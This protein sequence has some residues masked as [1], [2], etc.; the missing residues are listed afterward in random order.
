MA[1]LT[2]IAFHTLALAVAVASAT[3]LQAWNS[4]EISANDKT[5]D[6]GRDGSRE[7]RQHGAFFKNDMVI[8]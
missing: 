7:V 4:R 2:T 8:E 3:Y 1:Q 6:I 5:N